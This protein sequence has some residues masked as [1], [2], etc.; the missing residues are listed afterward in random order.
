MRQSATRWLFLGTT[1]VVLIV[2]GVMLYKRQKVIDERWEIIA[3]RHKIITG[4]R[5]TKG[6]NGVWDDSD[7]PFPDKDGAQP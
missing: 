4:V 5:P 7:F 6:A 1:A 3:D 2:N